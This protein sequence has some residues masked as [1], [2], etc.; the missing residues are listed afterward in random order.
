MAQEILSLFFTNSSPDESPAG[1]FKGAE[2][3]RAFPS[4]HAKRSPRLFEGRDVIPSDLN[5][6][7]AG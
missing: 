5:N 3:G 1:A 4:A 2:G 6:R 7:E